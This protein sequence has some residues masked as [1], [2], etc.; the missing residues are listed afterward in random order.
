M[1]DRYEEEPLLSN[2]M[3]PSVGCLRCRYDE[4]ECEACDRSSQHLFSPVCPLCGACVHEKDEVCEP[5][6]ER[7]IRDMRLS[8]ER[9]GKAVCPACGTKW[10]EGEPSCIECGTDWTER[11]PRQ[12]QASPAPC[13][14]TANPA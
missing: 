7:A 10:A 8:D 2:W 12:I 13:K 5:C 14:A 3:P 11:Y 6:A 4:R 9:S 1:N